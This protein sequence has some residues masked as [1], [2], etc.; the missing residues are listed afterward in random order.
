MTEN[1]GPGSV[2]GKTKLPITRTSLKCLGSLTVLAVMPHP[3]LVYPVL[4]GVALGCRLL[5]KGLSS[6][7]VSFERCSKVL[8]N[9]LQKIVNDD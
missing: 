4:G 8:L 9:S 6:S 5:G 7:L 2:T 1:S 3:Y